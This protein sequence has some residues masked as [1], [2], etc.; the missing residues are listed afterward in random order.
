MPAEGCPPSLALAHVVP[1]LAPTRLSSALALEFKKSFEND[2]QSSDNINFLKVQWSSRQLPTVS[3]SSPFRLPLPWLE[4]EQP[5]AWLASLLWPRKVRNSSQFLD[6]R[7]IGWPRVKVG[8]AKKV[9]E[10]EVPRPLACCLHRPPG[11]LP[12]ALQLKPIL[13]DIEY[14][15]DQHILL[16]VKSLDGYESYGKWLESVIRAQQPQNGGP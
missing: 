6:G 16:T 4:M 9:C 1:A 10:A 11:A 3:S 2:S 13:S 7:P 15:Q 12:C 8:N 5:V 14:L